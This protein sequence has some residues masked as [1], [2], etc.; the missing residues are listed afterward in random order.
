MKRLLYLLLVLATVLPLSSC[1]R[2]VEKARENIR[3]EAVEGIRIHGLTGAEVT[4]RVRNDTGY[5]LALEQ[6]EVDV[7]YRKS[8]VATVVLVDPVVVA[9]HTTDSFVS[10]WKVRDVDPLAVLALVRRVKSDD[11]SQVDISFA[12]EGRGGP[13]PVNISREMVPL[14][15]ILNTF[16]LTL[17]DLKNRL[18]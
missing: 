14:S 16:G 6:A 1:R 17:Q 10:Q 13:A 7:F 18:K 12:A 9:R 8:R 5:N 2:A 15:E 3:L 4:V 11:I